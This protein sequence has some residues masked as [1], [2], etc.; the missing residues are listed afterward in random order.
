MTK[1]V[2]ADGRVLQRIVATTPLT[3][4]HGLSREVFARYD[5]A[6]AKT[7]WA[8]R[9]RRRFALMQA[10]EVLASAERYDLTGRLDRQLVT[11]CGIAGVLE[12]AADDTGNSCAGSSSSSYSR[13][14]YATV[15]IW[16]SF[17]KPPAKR[18]R[19]RGTI[20]HRPAVGHRGRFA[21]PVVLAGSLT[22]EG[23]S[24][25]RCPSAACGR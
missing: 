4:H 22:S 8:L 14:P 15:P 16:R 21:T 2:Q 6:Q 5:A 20:S 19:Y 13:M 10:D 11:I 1:L 23:R 9:H 25:P 18:L 3:A 24:Q 7:S 17:S 12:H